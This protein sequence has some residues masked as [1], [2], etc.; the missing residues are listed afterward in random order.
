M[1]ADDHAIL[2]SGRLLLE[3]DLA[4]VGEATDGREAIEWMAPASADLVAMDV[5]MPGV[6]GI[7]A[8]A[9]IARRHPHAG[10]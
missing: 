1:L 3:P 5:G 10:V 8:A 7:E 9:Q 6:N 2:C 4:V